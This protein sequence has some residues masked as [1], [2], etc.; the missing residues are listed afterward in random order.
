MNNPL[1]DNS[2]QPY[3]E[4]LLVEDDV[5]TPNGT[6]G[7]PNVELFCHW[8]SSE[9]MVKGLS[10]GMDVRENE[11]QAGNVGKGHE[12]AN[13][14]YENGDGNTEARTDD[15]NGKLNETAKSNKS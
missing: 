1:K 2:K 4:W 5:L 12:S 13:S 11:E 15:R 7:K 6:I 14:K 3:P 10:D 8:I 9:V